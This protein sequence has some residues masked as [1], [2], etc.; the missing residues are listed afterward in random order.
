MKF[1][2]TAGAVLLSAFA[3]TA[4]GI[5]FDPEDEG[6]SSVNKWIYQAGR[7]CAST[8]GSQKKCSVEM[9]S[10]SANLAIFAPIYRATVANT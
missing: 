1:F 5:E 9:R 4:G 8:N 3:A 7:L 2:T 10:E 6:T